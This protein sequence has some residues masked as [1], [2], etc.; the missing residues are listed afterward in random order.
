[1][2]GRRTRRNSEAGG[3]GGIGGYISAPEGV[4]RPARKKSSF[5]TIHKPP[6]R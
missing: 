1:M 5:S 4:G 6:K 2:N 3:I